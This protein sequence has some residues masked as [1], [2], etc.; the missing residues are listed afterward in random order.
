MRPTWPI[1]LAK[2]YEINIH[3]ER[4]RERERIE[5]RERAELL[6]FPLS[7][8]VYVSDKI[9]GDGVWRTVRSGCIGRSSRGTPAGGR[10]R[11]ARGIVD[12]HETTSGRRRRVGSQ[13]GGL[14][15]Q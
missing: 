15:S 3:A 5:G 6:Q 1:A 4:K 14:Y 9:S 2:M 7:G 13:V 10:V 8:N 12:G 11:D